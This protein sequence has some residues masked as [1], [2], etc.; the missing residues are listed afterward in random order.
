LVGKKEHRR[1]CAQAVWALSALAGDLH[2][3]ENAFEALLTHVSAARPALEAKATYVRPGSCG[4]RK[5]R[6]ALA[7]ANRPYD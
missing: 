4:P 7:A 6:G 3:I 1:S 2:V 5:E